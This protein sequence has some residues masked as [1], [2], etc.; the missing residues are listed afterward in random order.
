M[1]HFTTKIFLVTILNLFYFIG[2][3]QSLMIANFESDN[4]DKMCVERIGPV[5]SGSTLT[6]VDNPFKSGNNQSDKVLKV[7]D[8]VM[9]GGFHLNLTRNVVNEVDKILN[10]TEYTGF[11]FK[12]RVNNPSQFSARNAG[13]NPNGMNDYTVAGVW[14][15]TG[16]DWQTITFTFANLPANMANIQIQPYKQI[17]TGAGVPI[18]GLEIYLDDLELFKM[19]DFSEGLLN[20]IS[21]DGKELEFFMPEKTMYSYN[22]PYTY[23]SQGIPVVEFEPANSN[24]TVTEVPATN[25]SGTVLERTTTLIIAEKGEE[26]ARYDI[27]FNIIPELDVYICLGQSNMSGYGEI[28]DDDKGV[29]NNTYLLTPGKNFEPAENPLNKYSTISN[30]AFAKIGPAYGFAKSL[31]DKT[32]NPVGLLVNA[33]N[34]SAIDWWRKGNTTYNLYAHTLE[35]AKEARK[36]GEIKGI[37]WHQGE[38][39]SWQAGAYMGLLQTWVSNFR[40]DLGDVNNEIYFVAGELAYWRNDGQG[41]NRSTAFNEMIRTIASSIPNSNWVSAEGLTPWKDETD[42]HFD[43]ESAILLGE[44][45]ADRFINQYYNSTAV[46]IL[47]NNS[48]LNCVFNINGMQLTVKNIDNINATLSVYDIHGKKVKSTYLSGL[49]SIVLPAKGI[50]ILMLTDKDGVATKKIICQ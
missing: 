39:D 46:N 36:W 48:F 16:A 27:I 44:R 42:P 2:F 4:T 43:R 5:G 22:L 13:I 18:A 31:I 9:F 30:G 47:I 17:W 25:L 26:V 28:T 49:T 8:V 38:S 20:K 45:Y 35:R 1:K 10:G 34:G 6:V 32:T 29:I 7:S 19:E 40:A 14:S 15:D 3:S 37:L 50:Y 33:R 12:Y 23:A 41:N 11:R 24:Q 21:I